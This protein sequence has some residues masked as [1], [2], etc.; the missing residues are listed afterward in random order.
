MA[1]FSANQQQFLKALVANSNIHPGVAAAWMAAEEPVGAQSGDHGTQD[2]LNVGMTDSASLGTGNDV[3]TNPT[4]AGAATAKWLQGKWN[5]PG[6]GTA[7]QGIQNITKARAPQ[8][9]IKAIQGSGWASSG[10]PNLGSLFQTYRGLGQQVAK[11]VVRAP[12]S[13]P[14]LPSAAQPAAPKTITTFKP[15]YADAGISAFLAAANKPITVGAG[16][17][18]GGLAHVE[19]QNSSLLSDYASNVASMPQTT[20]T[21]VTQQSTAIAAKAVN[22]A[23]AAGASGDAQ[24]LLRMVHNAAGSPYEWGGG[25]STNSEHV[26][27]VKQGI[28]CSGFVSWLM[29]KNGL[30]IWNSPQTTETIPNAQGIESGRGSKITIFDNA[31][32]HVIIKIGGQFWASEGGVGVHQLGAGEVSAYLNSGAYKAY[33]PKGL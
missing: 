2:W 1:Q 27:A 22:D 11:G 14:Q 3:W 10:Y 16:T 18:D 12:G 15:D 19:N 23:S 32:E 17:S 8:Q 6:F 30:G 26:G 21:H 28:D 4:K 24:K 20:T 9:Q 31:S 7:S 5:D 13:V 29:G 33:H 25:H